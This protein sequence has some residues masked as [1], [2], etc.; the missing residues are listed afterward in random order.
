M[1]A[2][3][4]R[5]PGPPG[6][7][8]GTAESQ[9]GHVADSVVSHQCLARDLRQGEATWLGLSGSSGKGFAVSETLHEVPQRPMLAFLRLF[10]AFFLQSDW[11]H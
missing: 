1:P 5:L 4:A 7:Q 10:T 11:D 2:L 8:G 9:V 6:E 3:P